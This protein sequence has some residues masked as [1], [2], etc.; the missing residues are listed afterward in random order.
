MNEVT[1]YFI[2]VFCAIHNLKLIVMVEQW[3]SARGK[4]NLLP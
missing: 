1:L 2:Y 4:G 3:S